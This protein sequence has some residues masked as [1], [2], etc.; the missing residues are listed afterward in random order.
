MLIGIILFSFLTDWE[1][2]ESQGSS[3]MF[4]LIIVL[5]SIC[6]VAFQKEQQSIEWDE[7]S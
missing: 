5:M 3:W 2:V 4:R 6:A 7:E 1:E